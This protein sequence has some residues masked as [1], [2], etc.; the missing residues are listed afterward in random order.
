LDSEV[1]ED[2]KE[3]KGLLPV[4]HSMLMLLMIMY[5]LSGQVYHSTIL[6]ADA[7]SSPSIIMS[8][9]MEDGSRLIID[10]YREAYYWLKQNTP[11]DSKIMSWW[12][13]GY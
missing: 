8:H 13:Y 10:D 6:A 4:I 5:I 11:P 12:D 2:V 9:K 1:S 3:R 7:Y